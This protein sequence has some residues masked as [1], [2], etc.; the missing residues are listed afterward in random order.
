MNNK[1]NVRSDILLMVITCIAVSA[2][3]I[4]AVKVEQI[5]VFTWKTLLSMPIAIVV[6]TVAHE[7][8]HM[9]VGAAKGFKTVSLRFLWFKFYKESGKTKFAFT[10]AFDQIGEAELIPVKKENIEKRYKTVS[11]AG[12]IANALIAVA[13]AVS[14]IFWGETWLAGSKLFD[15]TA[16]GFAISLYYVLSNA[17]PMSLDLERNDGA[18]LKGIKEKDDVT[19]VMFSLMNAHAEL[20]AGKSPAEVDKKYYF[21]V[22]Q[23]PEDEP[24]FTLLLNNRYYYYLDLGDKENAIKTAERIES[25]TDYMSKSYLKETR[26]DELYN[27]CVLTKDFQKADDIAE[28]YEKYLNKVTSVKNMRA[29]AA[30]AAYVLKDKEL[31]YAICSGAIDLADKYSVEGLKKF[32]LKLLNELKNYIEE[33]PENASEDENVNNEE[34]VEITAENAEELITTEEESSLRESDAE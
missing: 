13:Y 9:A 7:I 33:M 16:F 14:A 27:C 25:L 15:L 2:T 29:K 3:Y 11:V 24:Y 8:A 26:V 10:T 28:D 18:I 19:T 4:F 5:P 31:A 21:D 20:Y 17:L 22:P 1:T 23:L 32:E 12:I 6:N 34:P 30:Y